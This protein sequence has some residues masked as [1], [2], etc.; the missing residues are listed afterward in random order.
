M[1]EKINCYF[2]E[3]YSKLNQY[4]DSRPKI[5]TLCKLMTM[6]H[7]QETQLTQYN[8]ISTQ[9]LSEQ[10]KLNSTA[11]HSALSNRILT[12]TVTAIETNQ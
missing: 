3:H 9:A 4:N 12:P 7:T 11:I 1:F 8:T 6:L 10:K 5:K 2:H